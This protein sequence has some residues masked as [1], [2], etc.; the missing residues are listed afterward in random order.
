MPVRCAR[1]APSPHR[2]PVHIYE[3]A[4]SA[5]GRLL[6]HAEKNAKPPEQIAQSVDKRCVQ[7][8]QPAELAPSPYAQLVCRQARST[9]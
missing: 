6:P 1:Y 5:P 2:L 7:P 9:V 4:M 3:S 8:M